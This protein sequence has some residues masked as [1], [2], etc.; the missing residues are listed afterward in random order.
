MTITLTGVQLPDGSHTDLHIADGVF[1]AEAPQ[2]AE[3]IEAAGLIALPGLVDP[4]THLREPGREDA[5]T[6]SSGTLAAARGGFTAVCAM[7][8]TTPVTDTAERAEHVDR[9][10]KAAG[11]CQVQV[12]GAITKGL[13]GEQLAELGLMHRSS[14]AVMMFSDDGLC[15]MNPQLMRRALEWVKP[16]GGVLAQHAQDAHLAGPGAC[17]HESEFSGRL[18]L[19]AW[20]PAAEATIIARDAMLA[21]AT[22]S[23]IHICHVSTAEGV[24]VVRWAKAR[25]INITAEVT[26]HHLLLGTE[27]LAG[28]DTTYKVNPPLRTDE[29]IE[30]VR[31]A[32]ADGTIDMVGTDHAPHAPQDKDHAFVDARPGMLGLEQALAVVIETMVLPGR[33]D[34]EALAQRMSFAPA[35]LVGL[36]RQ[37]RPLA[38][39]EPANL[40]LIDPTRR[41]VVD[42][43]E[44]ASL[45]RN[46]PYHGR[47]L[48]DPVV[49]TYW[50]GRLT[51]QGNTDRM[52]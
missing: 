43:C 51:Y 15:V 13:Q 7:A 16:F 26:P 52:R 40:V 50:E 44:S 5:E 3:R 11:H 46:N 22:G 24:D 2:G 29:H 31:A 39:G 19:G 25:G 49:A 8:N 45:S 9:L 30:A 14:A 37:G 17:C 42:R 28:Y 38:V 12:I 48:P 10:G 34:W 4:H 21:E 47:D 35:A 20:P 36:T 32:L 27:E 41:K 6:V 33:L 1:V 23:R 18:G